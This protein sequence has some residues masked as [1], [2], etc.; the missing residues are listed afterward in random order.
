MFCLLLTR[1]RH[2]FGR[3][4]VVDD[5]RAGRD[6]AGGEQNLMRPAA[7]DAHIGTPGIVIGGS[8]SLS[9]ATLRV[10]AP[11]RRVVRAQSRRRGMLIAM[12]AVPHVPLPG[13]M[14]D[15]GFAARCAENRDRFTSGAHGRA[16][17]EVHAMV[18]TTVL[19]GMAQVYLPGCR[20][21]VFGLDPARFT[22]T[23]EGITCGSCRSKTGLDGLAAK[24]ARPTRAAVPDPDQLTLY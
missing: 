12:S 1:F 2:V 13:E 20:T 4:I 21:P 9:A 23:T 22:A 5:S 19:D 7:L 16:G 18:L 14:V 15:R 3:P 10:I 8:E 6:V 11:T 17:G 24:P